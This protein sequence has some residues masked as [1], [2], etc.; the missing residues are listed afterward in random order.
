M[1]KMIYALVSLAF[2]LSGCE[3][4]K[5][6]D[7]PPNASA[8]PAVAPVAKV[9]P[10][11]EKKQGEYVKAEIRTIDWAKANEMAQAGGLFVDVR[12]RDEMG[13][14]YVLNSVNIPLDEIKHRLDELPKD[15]DLLVFCRYGRRSEAA[16][17]LLQKNGF[18]RVYN[19]AGGFMAYPQ[20]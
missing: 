16:T 1:K 20:K 11:V 7:V 14:G 12:Y 15:R 9:E 5:A 4:E 8:T 2:A 17:N 13:Q 3:T 10:V 18:E 6:K 19:I